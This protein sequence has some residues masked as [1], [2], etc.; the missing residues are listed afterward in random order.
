MNHLPPAPADPRMAP[1]VRL[2][3][4]MPVPGR[5]SGD[6]KLLIELE[7]KTKEAR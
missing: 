4:L 7:R 6:A 2:R 1:L 5:Q 3:S